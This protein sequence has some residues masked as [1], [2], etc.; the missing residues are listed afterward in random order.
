MSK[1]VH[2]AGDCI[3][4]VSVKI[5]GNV[6]RR[7]DM[8]IKQRNEKKEREEYK[9]CIAIFHDLILAHRLQDK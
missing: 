8:G 6:L 3:F 7:L 4:G 9:V 2:A 5:P 1:D